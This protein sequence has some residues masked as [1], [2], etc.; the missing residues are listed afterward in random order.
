VDFSSRA[1]RVVAFLK[2]GFSLAAPPFTPMPL[3]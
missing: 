2:A 1:A 3:D